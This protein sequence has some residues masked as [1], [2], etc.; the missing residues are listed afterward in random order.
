MDVTKTVD[1]D[2][3]EVTTLDKSRTELLKPREE[4]ELFL[5][6]RDSERKKRPQPMCFHDV[7]MTS[8]SIFKIKVQ[9]AYQ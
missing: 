3:K 4:E 9:S 1:V 2:E 6:R 5:S 7:M 8:M